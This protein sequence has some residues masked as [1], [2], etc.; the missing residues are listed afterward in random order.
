MYNN[1][2]NRFRYGF[3]SAISIVILLTSFVMIVI[4]RWLIER[5]VRGVE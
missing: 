4:P 5:R 2:F 1:T 3:G